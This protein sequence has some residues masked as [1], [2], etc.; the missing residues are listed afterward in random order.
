MER[1]NRVFTGILDYKGVS[2]E[3]MNQYKMEL[4]TEIDAA[5]EICRI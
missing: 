5:I 4:D 2:G 1:T 3:L